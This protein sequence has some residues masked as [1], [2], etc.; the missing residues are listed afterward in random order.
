[1]LEQTLFEAILTSG[2]FGLKNVCSLKT[3]S[4][5]LH[6]CVSMWLSSERHMSVSM[7]TR[8][9]GWAC[10][11]NHS[12]LVLFVLRQGISLYPELSD[13]LDCPAS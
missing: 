12:S 11:S 4:M 7:E 6:V 2:I 1:M 10:S 9:R 5:T 8:G 13:Y 3:F